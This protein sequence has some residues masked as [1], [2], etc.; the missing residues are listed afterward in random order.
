[1]NYFEIN[2]ECM[3]KNRCN[4]HQKLQEAEFSITNNKIEQIQT[5]TALNGDLY[6]TIQR[7]QKLYRINSSYSPKYEAEKWTSQYSFSNMNTI[8]TMYGLGTGTF[9]REI[10]YNKGINDLLFIY[11][12]CVEL[13]LYILNNYD[14]TDI[15]QN[16][17]LILAVEGVNDFEFHNLLQSAV[18]I[19]NISSQIRCVHPQYDDIF[20]ESCIIYWNE[21]KDNFYHVRTSINTE[22]VFGERYVINTL[23]NTRFIRESSLLRDL[24][25]DIQ[26]DLPVIIVAA[27]PSLKRNMEDLKR[28]KGKAYI[29]VVD[30]ILDYVLDE[31]LE[32]DFIVTVDPIK[33]VEY[34]TKRDDVK[35]PLL[36]ELL[37]NWE[38]L[39]RHKGKKIIY[40][41]TPYMAKM[42]QHL[43]RK[44]P[45][46][47]TG[48]SVAT[49]AFS[50][51]VQLG[52]KRIVL[53][54]QDLAYDGEITHAGGVAEKISWA[55]DV[56]VEG[57]DGN[58]VK[59]RHDWYEFLTW[60]KDMITIFPDIQVIDAKDRGAKIQG[61]TVMPL[62]EVVDTYC[63]KEIVNME[64]IAQKDDTF[65]EDEM[66]KVKQFF[67]D[68]FD[69][70]G[71]MKRKAKEAIEL[72]EAQIRGYKKYQD[73]TIDSEKRFKKLSKINKF[74]DERPIYY[75]LEP[76]ITASSAQQISELYQFTDDDMTDKIVT[77]EKS[78]K[79][80][81]AIVNATEFLKPLVEDALDF[82]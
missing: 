79:I 42:Y 82:I 73:E 31:G 24:K 18:N 13:F 76:L 47:D 7:G 2:M 16:K 28:A 30:R 67:T 38:V 33:P 39:D 1:M 19:T 27:G 62:K 29:I 61:S 54:G 70:I 22:I 49:T 75:L 26:T 56:M 25:K 60:F 52:F 10:L 3:E 36:C 5:A 72:C 77:Y 40:S 17:K 81:E 71:L 15:L 48:A 23:Y 14:L 68:S 59:S 45:L 50:I 20:P 74:I 8:M 11:E 78:I 6:L 21:L 53:V 66:V 46:L 12:P 37:A 34:F 57:I 4:L 32:P 58:Q 35:I 44:P 55:R 51:C 41:C 69:D 80:F 9:A 65:T 63:T 43:D 64:M